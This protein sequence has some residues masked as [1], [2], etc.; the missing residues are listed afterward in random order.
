MT[1]RNETYD[2]L[3]G[4][5]LSDLPAMTTLLLFGRESLLLAV[6][7]VAFGYWIKESSAAQVRKTPLQPL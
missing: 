3:T 6:T 1:G 7:A 4:A 2:T 5:V